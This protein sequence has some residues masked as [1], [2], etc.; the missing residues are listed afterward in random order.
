MNGFCFEI[1]LA[2]SA[3]NG[4]FLAKQVFFGLLKKQKSALW[5]FSDKGM[6]IILAK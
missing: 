3:P 5:L 6:A 4:I 1:D 2:K